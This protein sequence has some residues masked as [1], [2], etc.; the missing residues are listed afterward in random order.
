MR[1]LI[2][3]MVC[4]T[5]ALE[6]TCF[7][8]SPVETEVEPG[9]HLIGRIHLHFMEKSSSSDIF[10]HRVTQSFCFYL[11]QKALPSFQFSPPPYWLE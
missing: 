5:A 2:F 9:V 3:L 11:N 7:L 4:Y 6:I 8:Q 10:K 1:I